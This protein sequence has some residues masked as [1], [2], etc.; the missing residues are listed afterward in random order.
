M[1]IRRRSGRSRQTRR[2][3]KRMRRG[4]MTPRVSGSLR[5]AM[6]QVSLKR[7]F[8]AE[9]WPFGTASVDNFWRYY[10]PAISTLPNLAE[11]QALF[12]QYK[13]NGVKLT[14]RPRWTGFDGADGTT[15]GTTNKPLQNVHYI[16]DP[17]S[18]ITRSGTYSS[19]T[20]NSFCEHGNVKTVTGNR[21]I[22]IYFKPKHNED[23]GTG[24]TNA[25]LVGPS[26]L[27]LASATT[28]VNQG[29]HIFL[30]DP[31]FA[32]AG[33]GWG[34]DVFFTFYMQLRGMK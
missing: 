6:P 16:I 14:L 23:A 12:D 11:Y 5:Y 15:S 32:N 28:V 29:V 3:R 19:A 17:L 8:W 25:K 18:Q 1:V 4:A 34:Y 30:Q 24:I 10:T 33:A 27:S 13:V 26:W 31:N 20:F 22:S 21:T 2:A 7:T 9:Y